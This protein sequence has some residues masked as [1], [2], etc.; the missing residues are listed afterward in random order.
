MSD[1]PMDSSA[2]DAGQASF[3]PDAGEL[4]ACRDR[5]LRHCRAAVAT[6]DAETLH[7]LDTLLRTIAGGARLE[8]Y[9][10]SRP[11]D[12]GVPD[13]VERL[14]ALLDPPLGRA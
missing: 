11:A 10:L 4:E 5:A 14:I 8:R 13:E 9:L 12:S 6:C 3:G 2:P 7:R 1:R